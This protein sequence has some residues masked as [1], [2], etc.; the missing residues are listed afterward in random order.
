[1]SDEKGVKVRVWRTTSF[2]AVKLC[3]IVLTLPMEVSFGTELQHCLLQ[4]HP[5]FLRNPTK[6][7]KINPRLKLTE[8]IVL[9]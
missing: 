1:M 2:L 3:D 4:E 9:V 6:S 7:T 8:T 5:R